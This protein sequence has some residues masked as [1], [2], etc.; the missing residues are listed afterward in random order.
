MLV[1][2]L[3]VCSLLLT[4]RAS[5][6][7]AADR[8]TVPVPTLPGHLQVQEQVL[9]GG[10]STLKGKVIVNADGSVT[11]INPDGKREIIG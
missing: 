10:I 3:F 9:E 6:S 7:V 4:Q 1:Y 8:S 11:I 5:D 2:C